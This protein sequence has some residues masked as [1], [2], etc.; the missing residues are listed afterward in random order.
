[1]ARIN[2]PLRYPGGKSSL[3]VFLAKVMSANDLVGGTYVEPFAGGAGAALNLLFENY[4]HQIVI[5]DADTAIYLFWKTLL[6]QT[7]EFIRLVKEAPLN[8]DEWHRQKHI[9]LNQ[10]DYSELEIGF[11]TFYLNR[12]NRS[13]ILKAGPIGGKHQDGKWKLH[14]RFTRDKLVQRI[15][16]I[17]NQRNHITVLNMD[18]LTL[19][20]D[21]VS[22]LDNPVFVYLDPPYYQKGS[23]LYYNYYR[24]DDHLQLA[25]LMQ[26]SHSF[27]WLMT[28]DDADPIRE[29]YDCCGVHTFELNYFAFNARRGN[30]IIISPHDLCLPDGKVEVRYG[31]K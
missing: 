8:I 27:R 11:S 26:R 16:R 19:I 18:A 4:V 1:M 13:G 24:H 23:Q 22:L 2:S 30:E 9:A 17:A 7:D 5:N 25:Q 6:E 3:S 29:M 12:C 20:K 31:L 28:Y 15:E 14:V 10:D 21:Y